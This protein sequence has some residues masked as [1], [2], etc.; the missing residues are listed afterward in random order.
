M[1][2]DATWPKPKLM[3]CVDFRALTDSWWDWN[4]CMAARLNLWTST[5]KVMEL[6][7]IETKELAP[8]PL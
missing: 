5:F 2:K 7:L 6:A 1:C 3:K 8:D 4:N